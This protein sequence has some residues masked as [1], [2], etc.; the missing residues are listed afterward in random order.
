[1]QMKKWLL[2]LLP[3]LLVACAI[4]P[5]VLRPEL[6][7]NDALFSPPSVRINASDALA[8]SD[9]MK[10][11]VRTEIA[12]QL[13]TNGR[14]HGLF[15]ALYDAR[16]LKLDYDASFTRTAA[17]AFEERT[18]NCISLVMM[19]GAFA[20]EIGLP[21]QYHIVIGDESWSRTGNLYLA[22]Q[23]VNISL[24]RDDAQSGDDDM[25]TIDFLPKE[26]IRRQRRRTVTETAVVAMFMN[27]RAAESMLSGQFDNAYWWARAAIVQDPKYLH[28]YNTL[29][30]IYLRHRHPNQARRV[31]ET[32]LEHEPANITAMSNLRLVLDMLGLTAESKVLTR[33]IEQLQP[34]RPFYFFDLGKEAMKSRD[35]KA[36]EALFS[37]EI[38]RDQYYH[39]THFWLA[40]AY[41]GLG[42]VEQLRKHLMIAIENS[43]TKLLHDTYVTQLAKVD[44]LHSSLPVQFVLE[45]SLKP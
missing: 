41:A 44:A 10:Q 42:D 6:L 33:R 9:E 21:V 5:V 45:Y 43:P 1:M 39:E 11:Y 14:Q 36:A 4:P 31:F 30:V 38:D 37:Q 34:Y 26:E 22:N 19:T 3:M 27:S 28:A 23:H 15:N 8:L 25:V 18:G 32:I 20:K 7:F 40:A 16:G 24:A 2:M 29:G 17:Q 13:R 12:E 35:F